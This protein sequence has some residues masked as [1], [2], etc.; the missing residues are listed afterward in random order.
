MAP[1]KGGVEHGT[2]GGCSRAEGP[3]RVITAVAPIGL[4]LWTGGAL[5]ARTRRAAIQT[6]V[7]YESSTPFPNASGISVPATFEVRA[8]MLQHSPGQGHGE[9][10]PG[11]FASTADVGPDGGFEGTVWL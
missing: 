11:K 2:A 10:D 5:E 8:V 1:G 6:F 9:D 7:G 4:P 3:H